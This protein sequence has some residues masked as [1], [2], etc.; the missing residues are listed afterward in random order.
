MSHGFHIAA[1]ALTGKGLAEIF[2][3]HLHVRPPLLTH[4]DYQSFH[5]ATFVHLAPVKC[6]NVFLPLCPV[7]SVEGQTIRTAL[8]RFFVDQCHWREAT[9]KAEVPTTTTTTTTNESLK[10]SHTSTLT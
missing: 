9:T 4:T 8:T 10:Q 2:A 1:T 6:L 7:L 5:I 3:E